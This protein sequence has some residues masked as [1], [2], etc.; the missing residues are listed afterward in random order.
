MLSNMS[1]FIGYIKKHKFYVFLGLIFC[2]IFYDAFMERQLKTHFGA[3]IY[4]LFQDLS[5]EEA[6][7][8][9][10]DDAKKNPE[11]RDYYDIM[12]Y[13]DPVI[14]TRMFVCRDEY[15]F[16]LRWPKSSMKEEGYYVN[17]RTK[18]VRYVNN[19]FE[20]DFFY[21]FDIISIRVKN[22]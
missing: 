14:W 1:F 17:P 7:K 11:L 21:F 15:F 9:V 19:D 22:N 18:K 20:F 3:K 16:P 8:L 12:N 6:R 5:P 4:I 10:I 2:Y 13:D